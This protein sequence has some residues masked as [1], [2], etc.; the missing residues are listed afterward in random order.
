MDTVRV[1]V[2]DG[3]VPGPR[4]AGRDNESV[5]L[6]ADCVGVDVGAD[7]GVRDEVLIQCEL[8]EV[9]QGS[10]KERERRTMPSAAM[11]SIRRWTMDL[12]SFILDKGEAG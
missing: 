9:T 2:G 12:S 4:R 8:S 3:E 10:R 5:V 1:P 11:R 6:R 7:F